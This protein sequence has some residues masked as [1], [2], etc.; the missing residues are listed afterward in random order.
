[1]EEAVQITAFTCESKK[2]H[3]NCMNAAETSRQITWEYDSTT[4][5]C[6]VKYAGMCKTG[7][8]QGTIQ[9]TVGTKA[10]INMC[11]I[12]YQKTVQ[13]IIKKLLLRYCFRIIPHYGSD[14][15]KIL[16]NKLGNICMIPEHNL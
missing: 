6:L 14:K 9:T 3:N 15:F 13:P 1:M 16:L 5:T 12:T 7:L 11:T 8:F 2:G 4:P 10:E